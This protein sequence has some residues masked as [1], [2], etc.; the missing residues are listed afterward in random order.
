MLFKYLSLSLRILSV[1][2][3][4]FY[5][6]TLW[7]MHSDLTLRK[8]NSQCIS[9]EFKQYA[10]LDDSGYAVPNDNECEISRYGDCEILDNCASIILLENAWEV[11]D[12]V[13]NIA[14]ISPIFANIV[15]FFR[16]QDI[17][18]EISW[19]FVSPKIS[20][21]IQNIGDISGNYHATTQNVAQAQKNIPPWLEKVDFVFFQSFSFLIAGEGR[22]EICAW[23]Q[24]WFECWIAIIATNNEDFVDL[25][26]K[27]S[28]TISFLPLTAMFK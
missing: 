22:V 14:E 7:C 28:E 17:A 24:G 15:I 12:S 21:Y 11:L 10:I 3:T 9:L 16:R 1:E 26:L 20:W 8:R 18:E 25:R 13:D 19:Y 6:F 2:A 23:C 27:N 4:Y 5:M